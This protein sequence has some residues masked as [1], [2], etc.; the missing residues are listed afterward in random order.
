MPAQRKN[1][2]KRNLYI[3]FFLAALITLPNL[4]QAQTIEGM[5]R[6]IVDIVV[7]VGYAVVVVFWVITGI[8]FLTALGAPEKLG[9]AKRALFMAIGGTVIV[10]LAT[11][12]IAIITNSLLR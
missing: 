5:V 2:M 4:T 3:L 10:V 9:N 1:K 12:A 8:L 11:S 6:N 7:F